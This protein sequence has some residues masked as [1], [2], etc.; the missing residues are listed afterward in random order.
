MLAAIFR[1]VDKWPG[2]PT[3]PHKQKDGPFAVAYSKLLDDLE[4]ELTA[5]RAKD[6]VIQGYWQREQ[7]RNDG[8]PRSGQNPSGPGII[9]SFLKKGKPISMP[10]DT[11]KQW[12]QNLRA[13]NL[14]LTA[15]R[16]INRYGV[17]Q[18]D[19]QYKGFAKL[20]APKNTA[21]EALQF[22]V[23]LIEW[24]PDHVKADLEAAYKAAARQAHPDLNG[25]SHEMFVRLQQHYQTLKKTL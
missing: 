5:I 19:E 2:D 6:I 24:S 10:C 25:G 15:L 13:I 4:R 1:P 12:Q 3:A 22:I 11:Y 23:T 17:T 14:T 7:I 21:A 18:R 20:E 16:A 9:L 8:W